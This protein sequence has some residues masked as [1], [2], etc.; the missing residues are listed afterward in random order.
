MNSQNVSLIHPVTLKERLEQGEDICLVDVREDWEFSL[1]AIEGSVC[2]PLGE[3]A[4]RV[5]E[6]LFEEEIVVICH[7]GQRSHTGAQILM[8]SG[9][10]KVHNL[11][12]GIDAWSQLVD[13]TVPRYGPNG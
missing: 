1:A 9:F 13:P 5:Q 12:G 11:Q 7:H 3:L 8:E 2:L 6:L 10:K 4:D